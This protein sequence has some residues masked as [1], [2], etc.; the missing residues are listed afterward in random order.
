MSYKVRLQPSGYHFTVKDN[1]TVLDAALRQGL[2]LPYGCRNGSCGSCK[3]KLIDGEVRHLDYDP[4]ALTASEKE[5]G[6]TLLCRAEPQSDLTIDI[7][8]IRSGGEIPVRSMPARVVKMETL[9]HDV[10]R[11]YLKLP[12][13]GRLQFLAGQYIDVILKD[14][15]R[16]S[17]SIANSPENDEFIELHIRNVEGGIFSEQVFSLMKEKAVL[18]LEGPFGHFYLREGVGRPMIFVAGGTGFAPVKGIIEHAL[19]EGVSRPIHFYWGVR[20]RRD[21]YLDGL[22]RRW[23]K[24]YNDVHYTAILSEPMEEDRWRGRTGYVHQAVVEDFGD[25]KNYDV[26][27]SGP[28][29][30]VKSAYE[31]FVANG[32]DPEHFYSDAFEYAK[33][34]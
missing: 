1:E 28:P 18:R 30:M 23:V 7:K 21:L 34:K 10:M 26:Y 5:Q 13:G 25:L 17:F 20:A 4:A 32:L 9:A 27:A 8:E 22:P 15:K 19:A 11:L 31:A 24:D 33:D 12:A 29:V 6:M 3:G 14:N 16:R 2:V